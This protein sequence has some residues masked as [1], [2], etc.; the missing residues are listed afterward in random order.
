[1]R[2]LLF[3]AFVLSTGVAAGQDAGP[4]AVVEKAVAAHG[5]AAA[6]TK[7]PAS[8][9]KFKGQMTVLGT[10]VDFT[11][12]AAN[13]TPDKFRV[14]IEAD[15]GGVKQKFVMVVNGDK[16]RS[17]QNDAAGPVTPEIK[18]EAQ[19]LLLVQ[20]ISTLAPLLTDKFTLAAAKDEKVG[21]ADAAVVV[22]TGGGLKEVKLYFDQEV[23][24]AGQDQPQGAGPGPDDAGH[25]GVGDD[26]LQGSQR[27]QAAARGDGHPRRQEVHDLDDDR[28]Q[29]AGQAGPGPVRRRRQAGRRQ[30][31]AEAGGQKPEKKED[32][33]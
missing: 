21:D 7:Y 6:L 31:R 24:A 15:V 14:A 19:Q 25:R 20:Q 23:G 5:G 33:K 13:Q 12:D 28:D 1:M 32:K 27:G 2:K 17:V 22:V 10:D 18:A 4:K 16:V 11:G 3:A 9:A 26:R 30:G 29:D 8:T